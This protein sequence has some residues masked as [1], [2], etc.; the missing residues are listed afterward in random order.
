MDTNVPFLA[1]NT[2]AWLV[3][4]SV[5][6]AAIGVFASIIAKQKQYDR[7]YVIE[8]VCTCIMIAYSF[9]ALYVIKVLDVSIDY[10]NIAIYLSI[11]YLA[12][13]FIIQPWLVKKYLL[14]QK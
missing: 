6:L 1:T 7:P 10:D 2:V 11:W 13:F 3:F 8:T 5:L 14:R 4:V 9:Y 12:L